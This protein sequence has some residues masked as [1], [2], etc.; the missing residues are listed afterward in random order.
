MTFRMR[1]LYSAW[2]AAL[3]FGTAAARAQA[4][5]ET[6]SFDEVT[7]RL[8]RGGSLYVYLSTAQWLDGLSKNIAGYRE[9]L[10]AQSKTPEE[11]EK[12]GRYFDL[13]IDLLQKSGLEQI[14]G[15]GLSSLA[16]EPG[17]YRNT[18]FLHH[19]RG[20]DTGFLG[21]ASGGSPHPLA[22]LDLLPANTAL[23]AFSD[24]NLA[25]LITS[26]RAELER[27]GIPELKKAIDDGVSQFA[28]LAGLPL[29]A[30]LQSLGGGGGIVLTLDP[31]KQV[32]ITVGGQTQMIPMPRLALLLETRD[33]RIF[34]RVDAVV[35]GFPGVVK[36]DEPA[37]HMRTMAFPA[38]PKF[39][40]RPTVAQ[41]DKYLI[42]ATDDSLVRDL[43][44]AKTGGFK[45]TPGFAKMSAGLPAE[46]NGFS[47]VT[48]SLVDTWKQVRAQMVNAQS[49]GSPSD[50]AIMQKL[51]DSQ[52]I[53]T[54]YG[55]S[56]HLD[57]GWLTVSRGGQG[58]SQMLAPL[59]FIPGVVIG[60]AIPIYT[61]MYSHPAP[62]PPVENKSAES[63]EKAKRIYAAC[64]EYA[65]DHN[66]KYPPSL[67]AL[68]PK[69]VADP[70]L[71]Y[72]P[73]DET[74]PVGYL[75]TP[76]LTTRSSATAVL[77]ED[78]FSVDIAGEHAVIYARGTSSVR[79][80]E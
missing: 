12:A 40:V 37:L 52:G 79:K 17:T 38:T 78:R 67:D 68:I 41:T 73:Y 80:A 43:L 55:V 62:P 2:F 22:A 30:V 36:A 24:F 25:A 26:V 49:K 27:S 32:E 47:L 59:L 7:A 71:F 54:T 60:A 3:L 72:S 76:G 66:G 28:Q 58:A 57:N 8:D 15:V 13:G 20:K 48:Q 65:G 1:H 6:T 39:T 11:R 31:S 21:A 77:L 45:S 74:E 53:F 61:K 69:Y 10:L 14:S 75:Y 44:A 42:I 29:D 23:A 18:F 9:I 33:N 5:V 50:D 46:G 51:M 34:Q 70:S 16:I 64:K 35:G 19:Y 4:P 63:L 56:S